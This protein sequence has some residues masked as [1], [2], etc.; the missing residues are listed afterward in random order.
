MEMEKL[1]HADS[2]EIID[3]ALTGL[4]GHNWRTVYGVLKAA[5]GDRVQR[6]QRYFEKHVWDYLQCSATRQLGV[7]EALSHTVVS[8]HENRIKKLAISSDGDIAISGAGDGKLIFWNLRQKI[9]AV[10]PDVHQGCVNRVL[11]L[12]NLTEAL[13][14]DTQGFL[15]IWDLARPVPIRFD[16]TPDTH[17]TCDTVYSDDGK[18]I[19]FSTFSGTINV[20]DR[21]SGAKR[22]Q[23]AIN[24]PAESVA[25]SHDN[26]FIIVGSSDG[27]TR[28]FDLSGLLFYAVHH[29]N[30]CTHNS[31][32]S[33]DNQY[34]ITWPR[35]ISCFQP[36]ELAVYSLASGQ[37]INAI[38]LGRTIWSAKVT[39][40]N[41]LIVG[42]DKSMIICF[43][44]ASL[45][46]EKII[47]ES[48]LFGGPV[49]DLQVSAD[50]QYLI[51]G[52]DKCNQFVWDLQGGSQATPIMLPGSL[53]Q[54]N[55]YPIA[56]SKNNTIIAAARNGA[57]N[58]HQ[59][60]PLC[61][62]L[63][64]CSASL[65]QEQGIRGK[66]A[67]WFHKYCP[68]SR[69]FKIISACVGIASL[70][71]CTLKIFNHI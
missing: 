9:T 42:C 56:I 31:L 61:E 60:R 36:S 18:Y 14:Q 49:F 53:E 65:A 55:G 11:M 39:R 70:G 52:E 22:N 41:K 64:K 25:I 2:R 20:L 26:K 37:K 47:N 1:S 19:V 35:T 12:P 3:R 10:N 28:V 17:D 71:L 24:A 66:F 58:I 50:D 46:S 4:N 5:S 32:V 54:T 8:G 29:T 45:K 48:S 16:I 68:M 15:S 59:V 63:E 6:V 40:N 44:I 33:Y 30:E 7:H 67:F 34:F 69:K 23:F 38:T 27:F 21:S 57:L 13:S 43:D 51:S 62:V